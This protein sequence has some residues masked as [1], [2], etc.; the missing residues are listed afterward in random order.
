MKYKNGSYSRVEGKS[1]GELEKELQAVFADY[2]EYSDPETGCGFDSMVALFAKDD[3]YNLH[4]VAQRH[5][6]LNAPSALGM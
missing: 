1:Q 2:P 6:S 3:F 4:Y 5:L